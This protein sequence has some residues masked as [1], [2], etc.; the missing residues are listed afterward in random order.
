V[1]EK[2]DSMSELQAA[3]KDPMSFVQEVANAAEQTAKKLAI[4]HLKSRLEPNLQAQGLEWADVVPVLETIDSL[5]EL[6]AATEDPEAFLYRVSRAGGPLAKNL[7][8]IPLK[9][10]LEPCLQAQGLESGGDGAGRPAWS[11][12][13]STK[14]P[15]SRRKS[16]TIDSY[17]AAL[18][19]AL[20][21]SRVHDGGRTVLSTDDS[22]VFGNP[23]VGNP[24]LSGY[25]ASMG[26]MSPEA[27]QTV[28][29]LREEQQRRLQYHEQQHLWTTN[30]RVAQERNLL[31]MSAP[32]IDSRNTRIDLTKNENTSSKR[33]VVYDA[34]SKNPIK[35]ATLADALSKIART[36]TL[37]FNYPVMNSQL[38]S[39]AMFTLDS[40]DIRIATSTIASG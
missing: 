8:I 15:P 39:I 7:A 37:E 30:E 22:V 3:A 1:L 20:E 21:D 26:N 38:T 34:R 14:R 6:R 33:D 28:T 19:P 9:P 23:G 17:P 35:S 5:E 36:G 27:A 40:D 2:I 24:A 32:R 13:G 12:N 11:G 10:R 4:M 29:V 31:A 25:Y 16:L 18:A